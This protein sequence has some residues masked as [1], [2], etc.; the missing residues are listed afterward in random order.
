LAGRSRVLDA[1]IVTAAARPPEQR[2][3]ATEQVIREE[4]GKTELD[5][6]NVAAQLARQFPDYAE[7]ASP[8]PVELKEAQALLEPDEA[9]LAFAVGKDSSFVFVARNER[10][11][12]FDVKVGSAEL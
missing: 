5:L 7:I 11:E 8:R 9:I 12:F 1:A 2:K 10:T 4:L 3:P 6:K